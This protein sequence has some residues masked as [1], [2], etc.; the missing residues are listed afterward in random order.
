MKQNID[1]PPPM[2]IQGSG[3]KTFVVTVTYGKRRDL[4]L[5]V[6]ESA[7]GQGIQKAVVVDN[8]SEW[9]VAGELGEIYGDWVDV[10]TS[11]KNRGS[12]GGFSSGM[13]RALELGA[14]YLLLLDDDNALRAHALDRL[15]SALARSSGQARAD[16]SLVQAFRPGHQSN[17]VQGIPVH[18]AYPRA[19]SFRGFHYL[20]LPYKAL[21]KITRMV[22]RRR[23]V[24]PLAEEIA[25]P[26]AP[27]S[28]LLFK[29]AVVDRFGLPREDFLLYTD[30]TEFTS[31]ITEAGGSIVLVAGAVVEDLESS[32]NLAVGP[33]RSSFD[34]LL[35]QGS[36]FRAYYSTRNGVY[37]Q[38][39]RAASSR[40]LPLNI[41][42]YMLLLK[43]KARSSRRKSRYKLVRKAV[44]DGFDGRLGE[45]PEFPL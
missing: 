21:R 14:D 27:Y 12:A 40:A 32:W 44:K 6:L 45:H 24:K 19:G 35:D 1:G 41:L 15:H 39:N 43:F 23:H 34:V 42:I 20:D 37:F 18:R 36:D 26:S 25:V 2:E 31:R 17:L 11:A 28:G 33:S 13:K 4:L 8:A 9:N 16:A 5:Q 3:A 38:K 7:R 30:D 22:T 10:T 29:R